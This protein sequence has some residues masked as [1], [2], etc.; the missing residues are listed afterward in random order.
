M[1]L[2]TLFCIATM[3]TLLCQACSRS[4]KETNRQE[5]NDKQAVIEGDSTL[6]GLACEGCNDTIVVFLRTPYDGTDPDTLNVLE[7]TRQHRVFGRPH[8]GDRLAI[9]RNAHDSTVADLVIVT[10]NLQAEWCY[11]VLPTLRK[12]ADMETINL[13]DLPDSV[14]TLLAVER[15]YGL[16]IKNEGAALPI[17]LQYLRKQLPEDEALVDYPPLKL[18]FEW[19]IYNGLLVLQS[20]RTDSTGARSL[21]VSDT[22]TIELLGPDTLVLQFNDYEQGFYKRVAAENEESRGN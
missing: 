8:I 1:T 21:V 11:K 9:L 19:H 5:L 20:H 6:Y 22:A 14:K 15:E 10:E 13:S 4:N 12:R 18:Y 2:K 16:H 3:A 17:G 7:A